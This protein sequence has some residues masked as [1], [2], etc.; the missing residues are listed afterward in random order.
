MQMQSFYI[1]VVEWIQTVPKCE[2]AIVVMEGVSMYLALEE[3]NGVLYNLADHFEQVSILMDCYT[4]FAAN[5]SKY[6]NPINEVGVTVV[7]G[8]DD[9]KQL[10]GEKIRFVQEHEL[11]P[12]YLI[13]E[14]KGIE[15]L[16]FH[17]IFGGSFSKKMYRLYEYK[18]KERE[19]E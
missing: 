9:P 1:S 15:K 12:K 4:T 16:I 18:S 19:E 11:T 3:L 13:N 8:I 5:A 2:N 17:K 7:H 6:K 10:Q 14:L